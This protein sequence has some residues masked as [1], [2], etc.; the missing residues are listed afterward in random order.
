MNNTENSH[1]LLD[2]T[3]ADQANSVNLTMSNIAHVELYTNI[4]LP[5][6]LCNKALVP[7]VYCKSRSAL[8]NLFATAG[9]IE[10]IFFNHSC[11]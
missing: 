3:F 10:L 4:S 1:I 7:S 11:Q 9:H 8:H 2:F 5:I 6:N